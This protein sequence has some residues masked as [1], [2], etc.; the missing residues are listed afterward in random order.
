MTYTRQLLFPH[1]WNN[2]IFS[3][4][5]CHPYPYSDP[6]YSFPLFTT[7]K[8][9]YFHLCLFTLLWDILSGVHSVSASVFGV[10]ISLTWYLS[11]EHKNIRRLQKASWSTQDSSCAPNIYLSSV[12]HTVTTVHS[13]KNFSSLLLPFFHHL[14]CCY[15]WT[16]L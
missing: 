12:M 13:C 5:T 7:I 3:L 8:Q 16:F 10:V 14:H 15:V 9:I 1:P 2:P 11:L 4:P 6:L